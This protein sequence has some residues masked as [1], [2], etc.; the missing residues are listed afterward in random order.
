MK[1]IAMTLGF[2]IAT[3]L[4]ASAQDA[5]PPQEQPID[6]TQ[7]EVVE[8]QGE[9]A[10]SPLNQEQGSQDVSQENQSGETEGVA[11]ITESEL[12]EE[13]TK[14]LQDSEFSQATIEEVYVLDGDAVDKLMQNDAEQFYI[15]DQNP[16]KI[17]QLQVQDEN[18][19]NV[20]YFDDQ[21]ELLGSKSI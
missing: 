13:V 6:E 20:L 21:G 19:K 7:E 18:E 11:S 5:N 16:D 15:G 8:M 14:G 17:Y 1:K 4:A 12:P 9:N 10:D 3:T 2:A